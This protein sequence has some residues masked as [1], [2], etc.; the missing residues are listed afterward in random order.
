MP[1]KPARDRLKAQSEKPTPPTSN[2]NE[3]FIFAWK[4]AASSVLSKAHGIT[5]LPTRKALGR[6]DNISEKDG[7]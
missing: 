7:L 2:L 6:I 5:K 1:D 4:N 3:R